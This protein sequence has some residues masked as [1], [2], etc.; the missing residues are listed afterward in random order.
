MLFCQTNEV[1]KAKTDFDI[2]KKQCPKLSKK[3]DSQ[4]KPFLEFYNKTGV[5]YGQKGNYNKALKYFN[6]ALVLDSNFSD[7]KQN[8]LY[9]KKMIKEN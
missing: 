1:A 3:I 8:I 9:A 5:Y 2:A 7:A 6:M 4:I